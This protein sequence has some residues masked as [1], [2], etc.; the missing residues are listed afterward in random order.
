MERIPGMRVVGGA[1]EEY[2]QQERKRIESLLYENHLDSLNETDR[3]E[4]EEHEIEKSPSHLA[5]INFAN[6]YSNQLREDAGVESYDIPD[7]NFHLMPRKLYEKAFGTNSGGVAL[8]KHQA[9]A[10]NADRFKDNPISFALTTVHETLHLKGHQV[11]EVEDV[12]DGTRTSLRRMGFSALSSQKNNNEGKD[13]EHFLGLHEAVVSELEKRSIPEILKLESLKEEV[14]RLSRAD[15]LDTIKDI[16]QNKKIP[17]DEIIWIS[18]DKSEFRTLPYRAQRQVLDYVC[19][20]IFSQFPADFEFVDNVYNLFFQS[21]FSGKLLSI[22]YY[23]EQTFGTN[24]FR[25][26]GNMGRD[27]GSAVLCLETLKKMRADS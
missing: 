2:K 17:V 23:V 10:L 6:E 22:A 12:E 7:R 8:Q 25:T 16:S 14:A 11:S 19:N 18:K 26:L 15:N 13:H 9:V 5:A 4:L 21:Q 3:D 1:S 27:P 24:G 20:E